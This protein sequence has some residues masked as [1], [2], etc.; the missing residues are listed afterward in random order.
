MEHFSRAQWMRA[1]SRY[2]MVETPHSKQSA[3]HAAV[4]KCTDNMLIQ[5]ISRYGNRDI[6]SDQKTHKLISIYL[7]TH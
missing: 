6:V 3:S 7:V 1:L 2:Q 5:N 4:Y